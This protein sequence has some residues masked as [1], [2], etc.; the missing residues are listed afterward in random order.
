MFTAEVF[1]LHVQMHAQVR[2]AA[3]L[4]EFAQQFWTGNLAHSSP[5]RWSPAVQEHRPQWSG[6]LELLGAVTFERDFQIIDG[7]I[8]FAQQFLEGGAPVGGESDHWSAPNINVGL[9]TVRLGFARPNDLLEVAP[10]LGVDVSEYYTHNTHLSMSLAFSKS[11]RN[12]EKGIMQRMFH[13][14]GEWRNS[15]SL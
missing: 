1:G 10:N 9:E 13:M 8:D 3:G 7:W 2:R 5:V 14:T 15:K 12:L 11:T 6:R 4:C